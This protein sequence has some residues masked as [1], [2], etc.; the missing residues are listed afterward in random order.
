[1]TSESFRIPGRSDLLWLAVD[2][3]GTLAENVWE[4]DTLSAIGPV[5]EANRAKLLSAVAAEGFKVVIHT[6]RPSSEY[7][8]I[9]AWL[10]ENGIPF[11]F[12]QTGKLLAYRYIDDRAIPADAERWY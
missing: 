1:M 12:V 6:A 9:E 7:E 3:D 8:M 11:K 5:I 2:L 4:P 10:N